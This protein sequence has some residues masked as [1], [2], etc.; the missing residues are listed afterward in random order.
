MFNRKLFFHMSMIYNIKRKH[1]PNQKWKKM[2]WQY[3][4]RNS[5]HILQVNLH[6]FSAFGRFNC[7][8]S[9]FFYQDDLLNNTG[10]LNKLI[11]F[12]EPNVDNIVRHTFHL[13]FYEIPTFTYRKK[14]TENRC[15][16]RNIKVMKNKQKYSFILLGIFDANNV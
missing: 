9:I 7:L 13:F 16:K 8:W 10:Y 15:P 14:K 6:E 4:E 11:G 2:K 12:I 1:N 5:R 3:T